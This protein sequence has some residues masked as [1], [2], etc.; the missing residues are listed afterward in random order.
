M[1]CI[2]CAGKNIKLENKEGVVHASRCECFK[3]GCD[4]S[5]DFFT[6]EDGIGKRSACECV[7]VATRAKLINRAFLPGRFVK[8][9]MQNYIPKSPTQAIAKKKCQ[10]F[11]TGERWLLLAGT[12]GTGKTHLAVATAF[13]LLEQGKSVQFFEFSSL[14]A[15]IRAG[16]GEDKSELDLIK[17]FLGCDFL[18]FDELGKGRCTEFERT[19][20]DQI[21]CA[22]W[23]RAT[24]R[25]IFTSNYS[26]SVN[27]EDPLHLGVR[28]GQ[29]VDSRIMGESDYVELTGADF[30]QDDGRVRV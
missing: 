13:E 17:P 11:V 20:L 21:V 24:C 18:I 27:L 8:S 16:Y 30:R 29:R 23:N 6:E 12:P 9:T 26:A 2:N 4:G 28:L 15:E 5:G 14:L 22:L 1:I 7:E 19:V 10:D 25:P 3:C